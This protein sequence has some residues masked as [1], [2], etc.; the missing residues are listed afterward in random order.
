[1][2]K[3]HGYGTFLYADGNIAYEGEWYEGKPRKVKDTY[4]YGGVV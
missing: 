2:G 1:M 3:P 4:Y